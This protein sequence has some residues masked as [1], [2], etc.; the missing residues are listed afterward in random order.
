MRLLLLKYVLP[1]SASWLCCKVNPQLCSCSEL[2]PRLLRMFCPLGALQIWSRHLHLGQGFLQQSYKYITVHWRLSLFLGSAYVWYLL[3][4]EQNSNYRE[5]FCPESSVII[6]SQHLPIKKRKEINK[7]HI[8]RDT[9]D[10]FNTGGKKTANT[11]TFDSLIR[12]DMCSIWKHM[13][14]QNKYRT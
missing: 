4:K 2:F 7:T 10:D 9:N 13:K 8:L 1:M 6:S 3:L 11:H 12:P 5:T 14:R